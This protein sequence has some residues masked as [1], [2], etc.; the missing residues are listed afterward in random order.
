LNI[1]RIVAIIYCASIGIVEVYGTPEK[2]K[3]SDGREYLI[4]TE[5]EY[6]WL[7]ALNECTRRNSQLLIIDSEEKNTVI[8]NLL[9][10]ASGGESYNVWLGGNDGR[11]FHKEEAFFWS[12]IGQKF[13]FTYWG[14]GAP[15]NGGCIDHCVHIWNTKPLYR[16][17]DS[18]CSMKMG[19]ICEENPYVKM[20]KKLKT[21]CDALNNFSKFERLQKDNME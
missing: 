12:T 17:K 8:V 18:E 16:W 11:S 1:A 19:F 2:H 15:N 4:E 14:Y 6:N 13:T 3:A 10:E 20:D 5:Y 21:G 7:E 9:K